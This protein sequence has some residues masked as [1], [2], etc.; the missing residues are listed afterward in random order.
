MVPTAELKVCPVCRT[1]VFAD[2]GTCY[3]CMY[4]FG[5]NEK[6]EN[7]QGECGPVECA[8]AECL[9]GV[10]EECLLGHFLVEFEGF[11]RGFLADRQIGVQ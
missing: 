1:N 6:L 4:K 9:P 8:Q 3:N 2:M 11:L 10:A 5:T 7:A